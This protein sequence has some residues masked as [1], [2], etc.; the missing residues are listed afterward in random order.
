MNRREVMTAIG[1]VTLMTSSIAYAMSRPTMVNINELIAKLV[2]S[3]SGLGGIQRVAPVDAP[4][5]EIWEGD[6][7]TLPDGREFE[8]IKE[9]K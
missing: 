3:K 9:M 5:V 7:I 2:V 8:F 1:A 6:I 4:N